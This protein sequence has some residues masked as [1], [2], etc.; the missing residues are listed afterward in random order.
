[1]NPQPPLIEILDPRTV[2]SLKRMTPA[3]RINQACRF[4][5][6][7]RVIVLGAIRTQHP[8]WTESQVLREAARRLSHGA[9][10]SVPR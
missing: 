2:E 9:T 4:W 10:E 5:K 3:E 7:A 6:S 8:D 1:M